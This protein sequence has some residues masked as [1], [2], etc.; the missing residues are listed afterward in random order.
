MRNEIVSLFQNGWVGT[1]NSVVRKVGKSRASVLK[2]IRDLIKDG[3]IEYRNGVLTR[4]VSLVPNQSSPV[5]EGTGPKEMPVSNPHPPR[6]PPAGARGPGGAPG[7]ELKMT[8]REVSKVASGRGFK[9]ATEVNLFLR[10]Y[11]VGK[12]HRYVKYF[13]QPQLIAAG[14]IASPTKRSVAVAEAVAKVET[15]KR[16]TYSGPAPF[17]KEWYAKSA[18]R[19]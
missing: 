5:S 6:V 1:A 15:P 13:R 4:A 8:I 16:K 2:T 11:A 17:T 3:I 19:P 9:T 14:V 7:R 12:G 18:R 10:G